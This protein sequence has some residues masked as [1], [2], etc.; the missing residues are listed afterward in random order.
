MVNKSFEWL[1]N[2]SGN[3]KHFNWLQHIFF[4]AIQLDN[5]IFIHIRTLTYYIHQIA[6][7]WV[8]HFRESSPYVHCTNH[9]NRNVFNWKLNYMCEH[10]KVINLFLIKLGFYFNSHPLFAQIQANTHEIIA[11]IIII[12]QCGFMIHLYII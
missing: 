4:I 1:L 2:L 9:R 12:I 8:F 11:M 7:N 10:N 6:S 5:I 3:W